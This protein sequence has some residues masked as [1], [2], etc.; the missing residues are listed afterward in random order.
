[1][2]LS[3]RARQAFEVAKMLRVQARFGVAVTPNMWVFCGERNG[4]YAFKNMR[5][6]EWL[7]V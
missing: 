2:K 7:F 6:G 1:M 4:K 5:N 3:P